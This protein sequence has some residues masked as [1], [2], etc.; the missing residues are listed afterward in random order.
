MALRVLHL[1]GSAVSDFHADLSLTYARGCLEATADSYESHP[2]YVSPDGRWRFPATLEPEAIAAAPALDPPD[3]LAHLGRLGLDV[4][5]PQMFCLPGMTSYRSLFA[6]LGIPVVGNTGEVMALGARKAAAKAL[7]ATAGVDVPRGEVL[8]RG[9]RP[10]IVPPAVV[11][12]DDADNSLGVTLV[13][14]PAGFDAALDA[15][16]VHARRVIVEEFVPLGRE[17][18]CGVIERD[19]E[20]VGLPLEEYLLDADTRPIRGYADKLAPGDG[21]LQLVAKD[22]PDVVLVDPA[23]PLT[24]RV[25]DVAKRAHVAL[26][27]RDHSLFDLRIDP[28][29]RPVFLEAS[30]YCSFSPASVLAVMARA[31][32]I[33]LDEL[34]AIAIRQARSRA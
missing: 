28:A 29:G 5:L 3:A 25:W 31:G 15:A 33:E 21:G 14:T 22:D 6:V 10:T 13:R 26:G 16:F 18:R 23:D 24:A 7:V 4:V 2:A 30:L 27:C 17:V 12:P 32:G 20:L 8:R 11:K 9:E 19:G 34:L 1:A